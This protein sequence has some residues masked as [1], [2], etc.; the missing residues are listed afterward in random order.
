M[1]RCGTASPSQDIRITANTFGSDYDTGLSAYTGTRGALTQI[2]CNDDAGGT[3]QP[4]VTINAV[5]GQTLFFMVGAFPSG[6]GG[7]LVRS[8]PPS[9]SATAVERPALV[10]EAAMQHALFLLSVLL[11]GSCPLLAQTPADTLLLRPG[12]RLRVTVDSG[13]PTRFIGVLLTYGADSLRLQTAGWSPFRPVSRSRVVRLEVSR[14]QH[15]HWR[16]GAALG[17]LLG[18]AVGFLSVQGETYEL[19]DN[20]PT[21]Q[22]LASTALGGALGAGI[23]AAIHTDRWQ[24]VAW[25]PPPAGTP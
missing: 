18:T 19:G 25:P 20:T 22:V 23:G 3:L 7:D 1:S 4:S 12:A 11:M 21:I 8:S 14:G 16:L 15:S 2:A 24:V 13:R 10:A 5:A 6:P 17:V 9:S